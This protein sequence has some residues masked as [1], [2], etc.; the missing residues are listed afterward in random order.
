M[1]FKIQRET[2]LKPIQQIVGA[3]ERRQTMPILSNFLFRNVNGNLVITATDLE[4]EVSASVDVSPDGEAITVPGRKLLDICKSLPEE[5]E[6]NFSHHDNKL[7]LK[8]GKSRFTLATLPADEFP[9]VDGVEI[10]ESITIDKDKLR[11]LIEDTSFAMA[12]QDVRYY[13]NGLMME[14][15]EDTLRTVATDGH[16]LSMAETQFETEGMDRQ[17]IVPKK[18]VQEFMRILAASAN[19]KVELLFSQN[20]LQANLD[21]IKFV[22]KLIDGKFPDYQR[23]IPE[24]H[25][26]IASIERE[27]LRSSLMRTS[28]LSNEKYRGI[29]LSFFKNNLK[30]Q[31]HNPEQEEAEEIIDVTYDG[32]EIEIGFNVSYL[33]DVL[34]SI[35]SDQV[36][37][38]LQDTNSSLLIVSPETEHRKYVVMPMRL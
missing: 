30:I 36:N 24:G 9:L 37:F 10:D 31:A 32:P 22:T 16:R 19:G 6:L 29:R 14:A 28:I 21:E 26:Y 35:K 8:S 25:Q 33:I 15:K 12:Q 20:H 13:L 34:N 4:L 7:E 27:I 11:S 17:V 2:L 3:V 18:A 38:Y 1:K 5:N 23:V